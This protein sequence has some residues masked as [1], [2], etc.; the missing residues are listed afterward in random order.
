MRVYL[1]ASLFYPE[2]L[3]LNPHPSHP[4]KKYIDIRKMVYILSKV[5]LLHVLKQIYILHPFVTHDV[6]PKLTCRI[7]HKVSKIYKRII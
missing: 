2:G 1:V 4:T 6:I 3:N 7:R 5:V